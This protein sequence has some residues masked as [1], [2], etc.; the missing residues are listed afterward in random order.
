M[1]FIIFF[2]LY[3][4]LLVVIGMNMFGIKYIIYIIVIINNSKRKRKK[5][6]FY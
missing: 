2:V 5:E 4:W 1:L 6:R 3:K